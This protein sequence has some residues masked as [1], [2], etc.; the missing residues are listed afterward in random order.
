MAMEGPIQEQLD[1]VHLDSRNPQLLNGRGY[2]L[3]VLAGHV[4]LFAV[5]AADAQQDAPRQHL[6]RIDSGG[7]ILDMPQ[8]EGGLLQIIGVGGPGAQALILPRERIAQVAHVEQWIAK[9]ANWMV[10]DRT[11]WA[12]PEAN[13]RS[14]EEIVAGERRRGAARELL[15]VHVNSGTVRLMGEGRAYDKDC[16]ALPLTAGMWMQAGE[17]GCTVSCSATAPAGAALWRALDR[18]QLDALTCIRERLLAAANM[19]AHRLLR[20]SELNASQ[21]KKLLDELS[22]V[23]VPRVAA[24]QTDLDATDPLFAACQAAAH[25][26]HADA[27]RPATRP[28]HQQFERI[29]EIARASR[30]RV[31]RTLLRGDWWQRDTGTLVGWYGAQQHPVA[32]VPASRKRYHVLDPGSGT[33]RIVDR[34]IAAELSPE[35]VTFYPTLPA[36]SLSNRDLLNFSARH[37]RGN[38]ARIILAALLMGILSAA[39]PLLLQVLVSS[40]IPRTELNELMFCAAALAVTA[41]AMGALQL[42]QSIAM[43]RLEGLTDWKLQAA[44]LDRLLKLP[45]SFFRQYTIGDLV[46]R[47][48]GIDAI[49]RSVTGRLLRGFMAAVLCAFGFILM[50]YYDWKLALFAAAVVLLRA[51]LIIGA[52]AVRLYHERRQFNL[53]G[54]VEGLVLQF[55]S[56]IAKLKIAGATIRALAV[57]GGQ[58]STQKRHFTAARRAANALGTA[59]AAFPTLATVLIFAAAEY[60]ASSLK[61]DLGAFLGFFAAFGQAIAA[62]GDL[63]TA[64]SESLTAIPHLSRLRPLISTPAEVAEHGATVGELSGEVELSRVTFRYLPSGPPILDNVSL[65]VAPGEYVAIVG[66]SGSGK[67]TIFRLLLGFETPETGSVFFDGKALNTLDLTGVRRQMGVVLQ[68]GRLISGSIYDNICGGMQLPLEHAWDAARL[69]GLEADIQAMPMGMHT[70]IAEGVSTISGGQRQRLMIARA[71]AHRPRLVLLDEATSSLD[72]RAQAVVSVSLGSLNITRI[73]IAHRLTTVR[74]ADRIIVLAEGKIVQSGSYAE[75]S[76]SS[77]MFADLAQRQLL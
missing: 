20:R 51:I 67:S 6:F 57:W 54:K 71:I 21:S 65:F 32:L 52:S 18:F 60:S 47:T 55:L 9:L 26:I 76:A 59:E 58:F 29:V 74:E 66:P 14:P 41:L 62:M 63:A 75:L 70:L 43:L 56:G 38:I 23:I 15:W 10:A 34:S 30:L 22:A 11:E 19:D 4:D 46:D 28:A 1:R 31:R 61:T 17:W 36:R 16:P 2:A 24:R 50:F 37:A 39:P 40:V 42:F 33:R 7:I 12:I 45:A 25:A 8:E 49:R 72:N 64:A 13:A 27:A 73:V 5:V 3:Q 48:L 35:A 53:Q 69:A 68:H 77:G 44:L